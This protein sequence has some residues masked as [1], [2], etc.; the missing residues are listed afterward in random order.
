MFGCM[1]H[2]RCPVQLAILIL[3]A[4]RWELPPFYWSAHLKQTQKKPH[5][6]CGSIPIPIS[7]SE[8]TMVAMEIYTCTCMMHVIGILLLQ[9]QTS[10]PGVDLLLLHQLP[11]VPETDQRC[12]GNPALMIPSCFNTNHLSPHACAGYPAPKEHQALSVR[13]KLIPRNSSLATNLPVQLENRFST[14]NI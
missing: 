5:I 6:R 8:V 10:G 2:A 13:R 7:S 11:L 12:Q 4:T 3:K 1:L 14:P 9:L